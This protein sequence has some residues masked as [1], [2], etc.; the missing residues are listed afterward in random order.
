MKY[1]FFGGALSTAWALLDVKT[2][3][4]KLDSASMAKIDGKQVYKVKYSPS[5]GLRIAMYFEPETFRHVMTEYEYTMQAGL[6]SR[7]PTAK[8]GSKE[9]NYKLMEEFAD[10]KAAGKLTLPL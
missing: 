1:G 3:K 7:D 10:F 5:D 2:R 9:S 4:I 8:S 6:I